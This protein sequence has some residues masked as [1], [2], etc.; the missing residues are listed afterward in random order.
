MFEIRTALGARKRL[1]AR[2]NAHMRG[3]RRTVRKVLVAHVTLWRHM[4][5]GRQR[6]GASEQDDQFVI[7]STRRIED[8]PKAHVQQSSQLK[9]KI[10][11]S[12]LA[13]QTVHL[14]RD[15]AREW[16]ASACV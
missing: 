14:A 15:C 5:D 16:S 11:I 3:E 1:V 7:I 8:A 10:R 13:Y 4:T 2:V 9:T 12:T 6:Q